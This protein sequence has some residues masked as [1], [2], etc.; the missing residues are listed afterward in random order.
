MSDSDQASYRSLPERPTGVMLLDAGYRYFWAGLFAA[1]MT[2][3]GDP[4]L[5]PICGGCS[6][7][8]YAE[9]KQIASVCPKCQ[10]PCWIGPLLDESKSGTPGAVMAL[11]ATRVRDRDAG[12]EKK[13][14]AKDPVVSRPSTPGPTD[15]VPSP[16]AGGDGKVSG[17]LSA[18]EPGLAEV[19]GTPIETIATSK[20]EDS[21]I[22]LPAPPTLPISP[23][24]LVSQ[25]P[26][27]L[28]A[29]TPGSAEVRKPAE[30]DSNAPVS[31]RVPV[32]VRGR[33]PRARG[34]R[35]RSSSWGVSSGGT[36]SDGGI[37]K[38]TLAYVESGQEEV[39]APISYLKGLKEGKVPT[40]GVPLS[41]EGGSVSTVSR[42]Q[43]VINFRVNR[44]WGYYMPYAP[45]WV[46]ERVENELDDWVVEEITMKE[47][48]PPNIL[49]HPERP[50]R[51][52][53]WEYVRMLEQEWWWG[54]TVLKLAVH[55]SGRYNPIP[56]LFSVEVTGDQ[57]QK[58]EKPHPRYYTSYEDVKRRFTY[59]V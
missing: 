33:S 38:S 27:A 6:A 13:S 23:T 59:M 16:A 12:P 35:G 47:K 36:S 39:L 55:S 48:M 7:V 29:T 18:P 30:G 8:I 58:V 11:L 26:K 43:R 32:Q 28:P 41:A 52:Q 57:G 37:P 44:L 54:R 51:V 45:L 53:A 3:E 50:K 34:P 9:L 42:I 40:G 56:R 17:E 22:A 4:T 10:R 5:V 20:G 14:H 25:T 19:Q 24:T 49:L 31:R 21:A 46:Y 1:D 2:D 15:P